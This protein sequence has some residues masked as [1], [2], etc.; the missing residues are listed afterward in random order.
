VAGGQLNRIHLNVTFSIVIRRNSSLNRK[1]KNFK[2]KYPK[3]IISFSIV[4]YRFLLGEY[5]FIGI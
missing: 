4:L 1:K 3:E 2:K 5:N